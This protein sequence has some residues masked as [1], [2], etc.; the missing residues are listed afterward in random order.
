M[1]GLETLHARFTC[2][3]FPGCPLRTWTASRL[4]LFL[5][6]DTN[7]RMGSKKKNDRMQVILDSLSSRLGSTPIQRG[8]GRVQGLN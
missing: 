2:D 6:C 1:S 8:E 3:T 4:F 7:T 5:A